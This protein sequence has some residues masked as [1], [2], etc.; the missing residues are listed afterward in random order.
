MDAFVDVRVDTTDAKEQLL[1]DFLTTV[2]SPDGI[3]NSRKFLFLFGDE[4]AGVLP[5]LKQVAQTVFG[6]EW[7]SRIYLRD[8][9]GQKFPYK[10]HAHK[11]ESSRKVIF[12]SQSTTHLD[13]WKSMYPHSLVYEFRGIYISPQMQ[14]RENL[15]PNMRH[16]D[17]DT[18]KDTLKNSIDSFC[19]EK[20]LSQTIANELKGR[21][22]ARVNE[23]FYLNF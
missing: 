9:K 7:E 6:D 22:L 11:V 5:I 16:L 23:M 20:N 4:S 10:L 8:D 15:P 3:V 13:K 12:V 19:V 2:P 21:V 17:L 14:T 18:F 1:Q